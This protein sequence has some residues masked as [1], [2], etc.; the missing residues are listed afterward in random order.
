[1]VFEGIEGSGKSTQAELLLQHL[2]GGDVPVSFAR[3]PGGTILG[4]RVR[5]ILLDASGPRM[6]PRAELFLYL[7]ARAQLIREFIAP[8]LENGERVILDRYVHST[9]AYQG[10]GLR[11]NLVGLDHAE[12][13]EA[14]T[15]LCRQGVGEFWPDTVFLLDLPV[16]EGLKRL[17]GSPDR[18]ERRDRAF[19][20]R[21]REGYLAL[22]ETEKGL[23][24]VI[25]ATLPIEEIAER[26][27]VGFELA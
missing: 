25:D 13:V 19:H 21:V 16:E 24:T 27:R 4:E 14:V 15:E 26:V 3:E 23:F 11:I 2:Q 22:A 12:N 17:K 5:D 20:E 8:K 18:I 7:A 9:I 6:S 1:M 10:Y